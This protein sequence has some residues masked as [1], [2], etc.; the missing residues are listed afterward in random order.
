MPVLYTLTGVDDSVWE[1]QRPTCPLR[2]VSDPDGIGGSAFKN[3]RSQNL[4]EDGAKWIDRN[5][6]LLTLKLDV[7][8]KGQRITGDAAIAVW[9]EWRRALGRGDQEMLLEITS[10]GGGVRRCRPRLEEPLP[11]AD[12]DRIYNTGY[13][14]EQAIIVPDESWFRKD[15]EHETYVPAGFS[16]ATITNAGDI[17]SPPRFRVTGPL[18]DLSIGAGGESVELT[19]TTIPSGQVWIIETDPNGRYVKREDT[20]EN[21]FP[22]IYTNAEG[23]R[24]WHGMVPAH[25]TDAPV[26]ISAT[27]TD[28]TSQVEIFLPQ[29][30]IEGVA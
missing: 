20:G 30:F 2:L 4:Q 23:P 14:R 16:G 22:T 18:T 24:S 7:H 12:I 26:T 3:L 15:E 9:S 21:M 27:G 5:D 6:E 11:K 10:P 19:G 8:L 25:T 13:F 17:E 28:G 1:F 29:L